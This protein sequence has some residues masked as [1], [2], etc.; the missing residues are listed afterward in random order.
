MTVDDGL[1]PPHL[2]CVVK[3]R[4]QVLGRDQ[5]AAG[6][7]GAVLGEGFDGGP[8]AEGGEAGASPDTI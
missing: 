6:C 8:V 7:C 3:D 1:A 2:G 5:A 4:G